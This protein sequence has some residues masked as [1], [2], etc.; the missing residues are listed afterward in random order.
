MADTGVVGNVPLYPL[1]YL[2]IS[3]NWMMG[4]SALSPV[5]HWVM[6]SSLHPFFCTEKVI[7][8][9]LAVLRAV[10][11]ECGISISTL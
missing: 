8:T 5:F 4:Q 3:A 9:L 2:T 6:V 7:E 1:I 10:A 11:N